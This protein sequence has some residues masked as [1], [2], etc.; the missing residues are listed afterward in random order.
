MN[1]CGR[2][3]HVVVIDDN[4]KARASAEAM[5]A[6]RGFHVRSSGDANEGMEWV[7]RIEPSVVVLSLTKKWQVL[8]M[9]RR[10]RGRF[11]PIPLPAQPRIVVAAGSLDEA[12]ER[13]TRHLGADAVLHKPVENGRLA[14][15]VAAL[16]RQNAPSSSTAIYEAV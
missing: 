14:E 15:V 8:D 6:G 11:E 7:R 9:I 3:S 4:P 16:A 5:L 1:K 13:F 2:P 12:S 10:L